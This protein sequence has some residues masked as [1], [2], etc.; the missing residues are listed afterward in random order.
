[1]MTLVSILTPIPHVSGWKEY[2]DHREHVGVSYHG[3]RFDWSS[4]LETYQRLVPDI[5]SLSLSRALSLCLTWYRPVVGIAYAATIQDW[6]LGK[7]ALKT[8]LISVFLCI[9]MGAVIGLCTGWTAMSES[10][11]TDEMKTRGSWTN[12]LVALPVAF[13]SGLGVA[14][15]LLDDQT[16]SLVG[17]AISASLLPPA[18]NSGILWIAFW[19]QEQ[20]W[21]GSI[22]PFPE[23]WP[24]PQPRDENYQGFDDDDPETQ[25]DLRDF[26]QAGMVSLLLTLSNIILVILSS[27]IMFRFKER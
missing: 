7:Q 11:P 20:D 19:F 21:L 12:F 14:V 6:K 5:F 17:V 24:V 8:E 3:V 9:L 2:D 25:P 18:V 13:F 23:P 27:M 22:A 10:W 4:L 1:M 26:R 16:S 15:G